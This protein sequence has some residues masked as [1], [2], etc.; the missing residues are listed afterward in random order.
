MGGQL[1]ACRTLIDSEINSVVE[2]ILL[3]STMISLPP[4]PVYIRVYF[5]FQ[6]ILKF[7][8]KLLLKKPDVVLIFTSA[9]LSFLEKGLMVFIAFIFQT[10]V[11][12][13]PNN[14]KLI[15]LITQ[16][17]CVVMSNLFLEYVI[18]LY[19]RV[20]RGKNIIVI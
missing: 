3:D 5:S 20:L 12:I 6:R 17:L 13:S 16:D 7:C 19:V 18:Q 10:R 11:I 9:G 8:Y 1:H 14:F 2:F 4:P 15:I